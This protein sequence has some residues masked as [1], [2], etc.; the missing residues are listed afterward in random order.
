VLK[1][2]TNMR[3]KLIIIDG[4]DG[5]GK[6]TQA[7][8]L[9]ERLKNEGLKVRKIEFPNYISESS[10]L[11]KM[12]LNGQFGTDPN[13]VNPYAASTFYAVDRFASYK[14]EWKSF[15]DEGGIVLC[16]RYTTSNMIH[17]AAKI[18]DNG[19]KYKFLDW[20]WDFEF[21]LF[22]LPVPDCVVFL[23]MPSEY[24]RRLMEVRNNKFTGDN[25]KDIHERNYDYME[26]SYKNAL[27]VAE[28]YSWKKVKCID[29]SGVR[30]IEEIHEEIY[31]IVKLYCYKDV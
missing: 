16:D 2:I 5:S 25:T 11:I 8:R 14:T 26:V 17:Q 12:Y 15:Y 18:Q 19:E 1:G 27:V 9:Y 23:D 3:G 28:K 7:T 10:S 6:A 20:L 30:S 13:D 31:D 22:K 29:D 4:S 24:S 21:N